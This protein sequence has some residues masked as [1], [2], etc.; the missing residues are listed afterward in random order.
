M[1]IVIAGGSGFLGRALS[2]RLVADGHQVLVLTR[3]GGASTPWQGARSTA[4]WVPN[5]TAGDWASALE[6]ADAVVN[7]AG[8]SIGDS[9]WT[10][11]RKAVIVDS[12][13]DAT[14]SLV[15]A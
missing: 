1:K 5:G 8:A 12:R 9:R 3:G 6:G 4:A 2:D 13:V 11:A 10:P 7:L 14:R 15:V